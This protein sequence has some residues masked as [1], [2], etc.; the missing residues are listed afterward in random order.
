MSKVQI[1]VVRKLASLYQKRIL[2]MLLTVFATCVAS[3]PLA[4]EPVSAEPVLSKNPNPGAG[5]TDGVQNLCKITSDF[6]CAQG[7]SN[8]NGTAGQIGGYGWTSRQYWDWG[9]PA[10]SGAKHN[11]TT[12]VSYRLQQRGVWFPGWT[13]YAKDWATTAFN[14]GFLV[15]Q[16]PSVGAIAQW[17]KGH[18]AYVEYVGNGYIETSSDNDGGKTDHIRIYL[19]SQYRPDNFIHFAPNQMSIVNVG[20]GRCLDVPNGTSTPGTQMQIWD[21]VGNVQQHWTLNVISG[22]PGLTGTLRPAYGSGCLDISTGKQFSGQKVQIYTCNG[23]TAQVW[24]LKQDGTIRSTSGFCLDVIGGKTPNG[25]KM[26][27]YNCNGTGAQRWIW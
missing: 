15:N 6:N 10:P 3:L 1:T 11:C 8:Y 24:T 17:N 19:G 22:T 18:V 5:T 23:T 13:A 4:I 2:R 26:D 16:S 7:V 21:C 27:I 14:S 20:S 9:S 12:Y 25:T